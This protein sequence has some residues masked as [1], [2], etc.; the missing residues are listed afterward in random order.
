MAII[1]KH[2]REKI[3]RYYKGPNG[4]TGPKPPIITAKPLVIGPGGVEVVE[5]KEPL[6]LEIGEKCP[7]G[8]RPLLL[9][10]GELPKGQNVKPP[11]GAKVIGSL[12]KLIDKEP[13]YYYVKMD[14][15]NV[16]F[17]RYMSKLSFDKQD[18]VEVPT[19]RAEVVPL[20]KDSYP[21]TK[22]DFRHRGQYVK[23]DDKASKAILHGTKNWPSREV[24]E[25][26]KVT[27]GKEH[28]GAF[29]TL[30]VTVPENGKIR[31]FLDYG[32]GKSQIYSFNVPP[33]LKDK[34]I[35]V[36]IAAT[37]KDL[38]EGDRNR[39]RIIHNNKSYVAKAE[40]WVPRIM[41][42]VVEQPRTVST[43][44]RPHSANKRAARPSDPSVGWKNPTGE[45]LESKRY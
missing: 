25:D 5:A 37:V 16:Y 43:R 32:P 38:E 23:M 34:K 27:K 10:C 7:K 26:G 18:G 29:Q 28:Y 33:G 6:V 42:K 21:A 19:C 30:R 36:N 12:E 39:P 41:Y 20:R 35:D 14:D 13:G 17:V 2:F 11:P 9:H 45:R 3:I 40:P 4:A 22:N 24:K 1:G 44:G 8:F 15:G 31:L